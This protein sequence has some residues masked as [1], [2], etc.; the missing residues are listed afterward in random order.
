MN[1]G[2]R[3]V[4]GSATDAMDTSAHSSRAGPRSRRSAWLRPSPA[5]LRCALLIAIAAALSGVRVAAPEAS[6]YTGEPE[7]ARL[8][9]SMALLKAV[10][11]VAT[12]ALVCWRFGWP[13]TWPVAV[14]YGLA[15][16]SMAA[17]TLGV[18][19]L[20]ALGLSSVAFHVGFVALLAC[21]YFDSDGPLGVLR[22]P[23]AGR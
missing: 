15:T 22:R 5:F 4:A 11:V 20:A 18:W 8:L 23:R 7:L 12:A 9:R 6:A 21:A 1:R 2:I 3:L 16:A 19:Q 14:V 10:L 13:V 17:A